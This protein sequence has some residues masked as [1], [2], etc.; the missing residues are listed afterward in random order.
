MTLAEGTVQVDTTAHFTMAF[1]SGGD[2]WTVDLSGDLSEELEKKSSRSGKNSF[3]TARG[4]QGL[5]VRE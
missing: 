3:L 2:F 1:P 5:V 4:E